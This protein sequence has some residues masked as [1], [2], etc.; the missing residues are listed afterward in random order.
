MF[1]G[2]GMESPTR[3]TLYTDALIVQGLIRTRQRRITDILNAADDPYL[4]LEDVTT[5]EFG[6]RATAVRSDY[7]QINLDA[8]L[9]AVSDVAIEPVAEL[10][11]PKA[12][13][14]AMISI[15]PFK[16]TGAIHL[17]P[18]RDMREALVELQGRFL[19]VTE[20]VYWSDTVAE[21]RATAQILAFNHG[22][23]Q[24]LAPHREVDPWAGMPA[25][26]P[27]GGEPGTGGSGS[28]T[29]GDQTS[30]TSGW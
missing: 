28:W 24:I 10:R 5:D 7:A 3:L 29:E 18:G 4:V 21:P 23:A 30:N 2:L 25:G 20:A 19:P 13:E 15:P 16:I 14:L 27:E 9:F 11:T 6:S 26:Q 17:L 12:P 22:R 8:V 1:A